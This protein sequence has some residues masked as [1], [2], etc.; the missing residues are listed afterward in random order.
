MDCRDVSFSS[1]SGGRP[2]DG[3]LVAT[4]RRRGD[5]PGAR[6]YLDSC[7]DLI[8]RAIDV[9]SDV[10]VEDVDARNDAELFGPV[11]RL[12]HHAGEYSQEQGRPPDG[13]VRVETLSGGETSGSGVS[14]VQVVVRDRPFLVDSLQAAL[15]ARGH[16]LRFV[17]HPIM[18]GPDGRQS[19]IYIETDPIVDAQEIASTRSALR[20]TLTDVAAVVADW[21]A[22]RTQAMTVSQQLIA[23]PP[24]SISDEES[25]E[26]AALLDWLARDHFTFV[27]YRHY[28]LRDVEGQ[29]CLVADADSG[30]GVVREAPPSIKPVDELPAG[31]RERVDEP[32]IMILTKANRRSTVHRPVYLDYIGVKEFDSNGIVIGEF[33]FLGLF[34]ASA[35][36][37]SVE[38]I[39]YVRRTVRAALT[40]CGYPARSHRER[41]FMHFCETYPREEI[42][43]LTS[44]D[45]AHTAH[46]VLAIG[47][48]RQTRLFV[49]GDDYGRFVSALV[50]L[51][52]DR[53]NTAVRQKIAAILSA[54]VGSEGID[55]SAR[56]SESVLA[57]LH[58]V[59]RLPVGQRVGQ[60]AVDDVELQIAAATLTW[61]DEFRTAF[62]AVYGPDATQR[63]MERLDGSIPAAYQEDLSPTTAVADLHR[64]SLLPTVPGPLATD[65]QLHPSA[66]AGG[67]HFRFSVYHCGQAV[68][69]S[70]LLPIFDSL[71]AR[72]VE[73]R[74]YQFRVDATDAWI[75]D[76]GI[77]LPDGR[78]S[79]GEEERSEEK[80]RFR[81]A[82]LAAWRGQCEKDRLNS[83]VVNAG[84]TWVECAWVRAWCQYVRQ[85]GL[86]YS[87]EY[88]NAI[89]TAHPRI[90][91]SIVAM[92][93]VKFDPGCAIDDRG[94]QVRGEHFQLLKLIDEVDGLDADRV[95]RQL[96][97]VIACMVRTN[98]FH[99][100]LLVDG[101]ALAFKLHPGEPPGLP[102]PRPHA[103][104]WVSS[105]VINGVHLRFGPIA[106]GGLRWS[107]R[108]EDVRTEVLGLATAQEVKNSVI[109]PV[110]AKGGFV[111]KPDWFS[112]QGG[113][114]REAGVT[115]YEQ[116]IS[117]LLSIT[118]NRRDGRTVRPDRTVVW[119]SEDSYLVVAADKGTAT[120][121]DIANRIALDREFWLGDAFA[122]GGSTGY[123]HKAMGITA[124][125]AWE[126]AKR[127]FWDQGVDA[128]RTDFTVVGI[129]DMSG[130][131]FGNGML[132]S[133]HIVLV[134]AFDHR[135]VF[136]DPDPDPA[137][138]FAERQRLFA[139][140]GSTWADYDR[141][142]LSAGGQIVARDAK[143]VVLND[144][145]RR[146]LAI[147]PDIDSLTPAELITAVLKAPVDMLFNGGI[148]TYI[149]ARHQSHLEVGDRANDAIRVNG[150][151]IRAGMV[152]EGGNLGATQAG[153][154][155]A[156]LG[157]VR[158]N[159][160]AIDNSAGV[161]TSDHE[162]NLKIAVS[163]AVSAGELS[164]KDRNS[165]LASLSEDVAAAV[166]RNN[167]LQ[168]MTLANARSQAAT[169]A[170]VHRRVVATLEER[171]VVD[172]AVDG[173]PSDSE[174][175][176]RINTGGV[177]TSPELCVLLAHV[178]NDLT[179]ALA[180]EEWLGEGWAEQVL[181][182]YFPTVIADKFVSEIRAHPV[183]RQ[184]LATLMSNHI[185]NNGG[186]TFVH[187]AI[188]ETAA[189][190]A[191]VARAYAIAVG[192]F[193]LESVWAE[194]RSLDGTVSTSVQSTLYLEVRRLLDRSTRWFLASRGQHLDVQAEIETFRP[195]VRLLS[196]T[197]TDALVGSQHERYRQRIA[198]LE[199]RGVPAG[200]AQEVSAGLERFALLDIHDIARRQDERPEAVAGVYFSVSEHFMIDYLLV[201]ISEL[202]K[203]E[204]W[205]NLARASLRSDIYSVGAGITE[206]VLESTQSDDVSEARLAAW[207]SEHASGHERVR[208]T[209][210]EIDATGH[211]D[212][213]TLSVALRVLRTLIQQA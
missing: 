102:H 176:E 2:A 155:E 68:S 129:G 145:V 47:E 105:P 84:L 26:A 20:D 65:A 120:F 206:K 72:V 67:T 144:A 32:R 37:E 52:R 130:D 137:I 89:V 146:V 6:I 191:D 115:G 169:M 174:L 50:Y 34:A 31:V 76:V 74:P 55:Y 19:W 36:A 197:I 23:H 39:P 166:L 186:I 162:V 168:N 109:V 112:D 188:E 126:S 43:Q 195:T 134:A 187:R 70:I 182:D 151:E 135:H 153:R 150:A 97:A 119:D 83:L 93:R 133:D 62:S 71:G 28:R 25:Q 16:N 161:D 86:Q 54:A 38:R 211:Y 45:L 205:A 154:V 33:R 178:K 149:K 57:R 99:D 173:F 159:T 90:V 40:L 193:D 177:L 116:F 143:S 63:L 53:Y 30:L 208:T 198:D 95:L 69:L 180:R 139:L 7:P 156:A 163:A 184:L 108:L 140:P 196:D 158:I 75:Y 29:R 132:C 10:L 142:L 49:R 81:E 106:R 136:L 104:V 79:L 59:L 27:G 212:L 209:L 22:M 194:I 98:A 94:Q 123:D 66:G 80:E 101:H 8:E 88:I 128:S 96:V 199:G 175:E 44:Q 131:V 207:D 160:D 12:L 35:F 117:A 114:W 170:P 107:D 9:Y 183:R 42:F 148:G 111:I 110:G 82:F 11:V 179:A 164:E 48:R 15:T 24:A 202:D 73:E 41:D 91:A 17:L 189:S 118:D 13:S 124:R 58:F 147:P 85:A 4:I 125:G 100:R 103:E 185:V 138:S 141:S 127:H 51:P 203:G 122:S 204:R 152:V 157:G 18:T 113:P 61:E 165:L 181:V 210:D 192:V 213:A 77:V 167:Y 14:V 56:V 21:D 78:E 5:S 1:A 171:G 87:T 60:M 121:S 190:A 201:K 172:R 64:L 92:F 46:R 200:L 3:E